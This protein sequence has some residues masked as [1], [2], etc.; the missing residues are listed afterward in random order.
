MIARVGGRCRHRLFRIGAIND[1]TGLK[2]PVTW[3]TFVYPCIRVV[4]Q[5]NT[6]SR[7][8]VLDFGGFYD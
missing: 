5:K 3:R 1:V 4:P 6:N 7:V 2:F 8:G